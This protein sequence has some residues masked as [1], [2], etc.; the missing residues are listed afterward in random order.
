MIKNH[1]RALHG[2]YERN[3][4]GDQRSA[5]QGTFTRGNQGGFIK[6]IERRIKV[7]F[8]STFTKIGQFFQQKSINYIRYFFCIRYYCFQ[9]FYKITFHRLGAFNA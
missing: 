5:P 8:G 4:S 1:L 2:R 3:E 6:G 7:G 9:V